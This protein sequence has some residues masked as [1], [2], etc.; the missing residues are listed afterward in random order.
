LIRRQLFSLNDEEWSRV[1]P[2]LPNGRRGARRVD[3]RRVVSGI[4]HMLRS[5][6]H[7]RDCPPEYGPYTSIYNRFNRRSRQGVW[8]AMFKAVTSS[9]GVIGTASIDSSHVRAHR[10]AAGGNVWPAPSASGLRSTVLISLQK[11]IR[12]FG[13]SP[14]A[15]MEIRAS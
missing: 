6:P 10:S 14:L 2:L 8:P 12:P 9:T 15:K 4:I 1:E 11:R 5:G 7:W 13:E 3:D